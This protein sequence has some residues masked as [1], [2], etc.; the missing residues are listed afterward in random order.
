MDYRTPTSAG[1]YDVS[2]PTVKKTEIMNLDGLHD[3]ILTSISLEVDS[4]MI[5]LSLKPVQFEG[6]PE[7]VSLI[8]HDWKRFSCPKEDPWGKSRFWQVNQARGP[9]QVKSGLLHIELEMT[10]GDVIEIHAIS[11]ERH[12]R[13]AS[14]IAG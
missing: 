1:E 7:F 14:P 3:A 2:Q 13:R 5:T 6:A 4:K 9:F 10:S 11:F 12:D 8:A